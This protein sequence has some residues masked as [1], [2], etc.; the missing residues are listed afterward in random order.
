MTGLFAN[1]EGYVFG[2]G[3]MREQR[4][5]LEHHTDSALLRRQGETGTG[6]HFLFQLDLAFGD[7]FEAGDGA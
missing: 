3:Q 7:R 6:D 4:V 2:H 5:I 1:A